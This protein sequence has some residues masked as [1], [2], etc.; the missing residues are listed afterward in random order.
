VEEL[1]PAKYWNES[2]KKA[3]DLMKAIPVADPRSDLKGIDGVIVGTPTR[4]GNMTA[5]MRNFWDQTGGDWVEGTLVGKPAGVFTSTGTQHG[6]QETTIISTMLTLLHHG[7]VLVGFPYSFEEQSTMV[8]ISG[9]SPYGV[10]TI[11]GPMGE[12]MPSQNELKMAKDFGKHF[13]VIAEK[14]MK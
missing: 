6:G 4:Y 2:V 7:C 13:T 10:S 11:A 9:G 3:K 1:M 12:R 14:L 8:E 5:Q